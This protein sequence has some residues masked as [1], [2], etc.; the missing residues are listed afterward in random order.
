MQ[1]NKNEYLTIKKNVSDISKKYTAPEDEEKF[2]KHIDNKIEN[3]NPTIMVYGVYNAGKS[4]LLNAL[5]GQKEMAKTGDSPETAEVKAYNYNGYTIY[6]TPGINAPIKHQKVTDEHLKKCE[7]VLFVLSNNGSFEEEYIYEKIGDVI[8]S[9]KPILIV[10]N[11]KSGTDMN[12]VEASAEIDKVNQH[13]STVCDKHGIAQSEEKVS[14]AFVDA[15]TALDGKIDNEQELIDESKILELERL[16]DELLGSAS[17]TEVSNALNIYITDY[18]LQTISIIDSKIDNPEMKKTQELI[19]YLEKLKQRT[20]IEL[21]EI[22]MQSVS[23]ATANLLELMLAK[24]QKS[25]SF[26]IQKTIE[27]ISAKI[28]RRIS[29]IQAEIK[30]KVDKFKVEFEQLSLD[31]PNVNLDMDTQHLPSSSEQN[32]GTKAAISSTGMVLAQAIPPTVVIP[33]PAGP[34]PV[35]P[36]VIIASALFGAFSGSSEAK[37]RAEAKLDEKRAMHLSAKN[38]ADEFGM[39]FKDNLLNKVNENVDNTFTSLIRQYMDFSNKIESENEQ[40]LEDKITL[41]NIAN[42]IKN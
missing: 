29:E 5:F 36:L 13:L 19:T 11:N 2:T 35:K 26:M 30:Q 34:I 25:I 31:N 40:L 3:F 21:K 17:A 39:N 16:M 41:Q 4:T 1:L 23:I 7:L 42:N 10:L 15:L 22:G 24:D 37:A 14:I 32:S 9:K 18:I 27:E 12:S 33:T 20:L 8:K 38:K 28:N 6:D